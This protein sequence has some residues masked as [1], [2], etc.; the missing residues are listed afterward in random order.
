MRVER[1]HGTRAC[2]QAGCREPDC[3]AANRRYVRAHRRGGLVAGTPEDGRRKGTLA[4]TCWCEAEVVRVP[5]GDVW[6][7]R[8]LSCGA[9]GC[10][11]EVMAG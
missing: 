11:P 6:A 10:G 5:A 9:D 1:E 3:V 7:R 4:V 8:T 2:Y